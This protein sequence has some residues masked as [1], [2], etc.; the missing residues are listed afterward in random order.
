MNNEE[1][2]VG[3]RPELVYSLTQQWTEDKT[4]SVL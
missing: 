2:M 3:Q 1:C 4:M